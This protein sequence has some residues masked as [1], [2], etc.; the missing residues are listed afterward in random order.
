MG[1]SEPFKRINDNLIQIGN[2][3][4]QRMNLVERW[5]PVLGKFKG[6]KKEDR[7][8]CAAELEAGLREAVSTPNFTRDVLPQ[9]REKYDH[10]FEE[11]QVQAEAALKE[12]KERRTTQQ[13]PSE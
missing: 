9:I 4:Y 3:L 6:L 11:R 2:C 1:E 10:G 12:W 5:A 7:L 8:D 13:P